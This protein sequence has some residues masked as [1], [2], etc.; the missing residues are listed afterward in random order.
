MNAVTS[1]KE[2]MACLPH[3]YASASVAGS[4]NFCSKHEQA[5]LWLQRCL[6]NS[7]SRAAISCPQQSPAR[8]RRVTSKELDRDQGPPPRSNVIRG[9]A[10]ND[11]RLWKDHLF[12][13]LQRYR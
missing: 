8:S 12:I 6:L 9:H 4:K 11:L 2:L 7:T 1:K 13:A 10:D 3:L 5:L